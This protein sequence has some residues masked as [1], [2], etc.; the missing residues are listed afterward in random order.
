MIKVNYCDTE[1]HKTKIKEFKA[2]IRKLCVIDDNNH[3]TKSC[4]CNIFKDGCGNY[5]DKTG[6]PVY[7]KDYLLKKD[8]RGLNFD[9]LKEDECLSQYFSLGDLVDCND[10]QIH[11]YLLDPAEDNLDLNLVI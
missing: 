9:K 2:L 1:D 4:Q 8:G 3:V 11:V 10:P 7:G 6:R 5:I